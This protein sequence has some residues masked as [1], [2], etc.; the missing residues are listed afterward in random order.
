MKKL[1]TIFLFTALINSD[2]FTQTGW[3]SQNDKPMAEWLNSVY[4][5]DSNTGWAV[6]SDSVILKTTNGGINWT[7]HLSGTGN[8][9]YSVYFPDNNT[10]WAVGSNSTILKTTNSGTSWISQTN[11]A[12]YVTFSTVYFIDENT[13]WTAGG[14]TIL[15][16]TNSGTNW[17]IQSSGTFFYLNSIYFVDN[18]ITIR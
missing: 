8:T 15:K 3:F 12:D 16:T 14:S 6:G 13:G 10:G 9:L 4:F 18:I 1:F 17:I 2:A 5:F 11:G 7:S